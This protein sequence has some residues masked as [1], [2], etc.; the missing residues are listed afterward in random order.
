MLFLGTTTG[1]TRAEL[2]ERVYCWVGARDSE[3]R[4]MEASMEALA[5]GLGAEAEVWSALLA[6][7]AALVPPRD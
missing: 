1:E 3:R 4:G 7:A 6:R 2:E 5:A